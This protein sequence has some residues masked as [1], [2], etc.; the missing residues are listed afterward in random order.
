MI[1]RITGRLHRALVLVMVLS[2]VLPYVAFADT[3]E[4]DAISNSNANNEQL[5]YTAGSS[6]AFQSK[7][8]VAKTGNECDPATGSALSFKLMATQQ[9]D[10]NGDAVNVD[11]SGAI[12][13]KLN[14]TTNAAQSLN[15]FTLTFSACGDAN[16]KT[17]DFTT[18]ST[19]AAGKYKI[20]V[21]SSTISDPG[22][23]DSYQVNNA[24]FFVQVSASTNQAPVANNQSVTTS[25]DTAKPITLTGSDTNTGDTL[26]YTVVTQPTKGQLT[27]TAPNLTYTPNANYNGSDSFTFKI[28]DGTVD[29]NT[30]TVS[31]TV[32]AVNDAPVAAND[33]ARTDEDRAVAIDVLAN[34]TDVENNSLSVGAGSITAPANGTATLITSDENAGKILYT[35]NGNFNG[36]DS[37]TYKVCD[38]GTSGGS[39][40]PKCST[41]SATVS[42]RVLAQNDA[43][44]AQNDAASTGEDTARVIDVLANDN[45]GAANESGQTLS[46]KADSITA[47]AYGTA[48]LITSGD[49]AGKIRYTPSND[50]NGS[51][52]FRYEVCDNG[53]SESVVNGEITSSADA[54]CS[55]S[56]ATVSLTVSAVND[57]PVPAGDTASTPEDT[58]LYIAPST[59][60]ENDSKGAAN[61]GTQTLTI[62]AVSNAVKGAV[63][64]VQADDQDAEGNVGK[65]RFVP[66]ANYNGTGASFDYKVCD[67]GSPQLCSE[68]TA[69]VTVT[70][71]P[72]ND[73]P[74]AGDDSFSTNEDTR[75]DLTQAQLK[76]NDTDVDNSELSVTA[77][78]NDTNGTAVKNT[79]G[80]VTFTP[81]RDFNGTAGFDYT[82]S[83][84]E[85]TDTGHVTVMVNAVNDK[86]TISSIADQETDEDVAKGPLNFTIGDVDNNLSVLTVSASS[87]NT[88]LVPDNKISLSGTGAEWT[89]TV[90]PAA[91]KHGEAT[92]TLTVCDGTSSCTEEVFKLTVNSVN[93]APDAVN[94]NAEGTED[95]TSYIN[96]LSNDTDVDNDALS[97]SSVSIDATN[98]AKATVSV[99][100]DGEHKGKISFV[101]ARD[102]NGP[103]TFSYTA[104]DGKGGTDTASVTVSVAAVNDAPVATD[105]RG[106]STDEDN[107][108]YIDPADLLVNDSDVDNTLAQLSL[109][110]IS[111]ASNGRVSIVP[112][113]EANAG[114]IKFQPNANY[115]GPASFKYTIT[116]GKLDSDKATVSI[117]VNAVNDAPSFTKGAN[118]TV[119]EDAG[120][121]SVA[122][123]ATNI[124]K[125]AANEGSQELTFN[126]GNDNRA[127]FSAQPAISAD[128][129]LTYTPAANANGSATVT[130]SLSDDG[131]TDNGGK[132]TSGTQ[133]FTIAI[134]AVNDAPSFTKGANQ[135]VPE[136]A[137]AQNVSGWATAI[138]A[139]PANEAGQALDFIVTN[140]NNGL[141]SAQPA[142][143]T[144]GTLSFTPAANK[145]GSTTVTVQLHDDGGTANGGAD[146]SAEQTFTITVTEV[147]DAPTAADDAK[148]GTEDT[149]LR[150]AVSDLLANDSAGPNEA[151]QTLSVRVEATANTHGTVS[152]DTST[153]QVVYT[154]AANY[155]G[156][157]SFSYTITDNG[158][159]NGTAD[160]RSASATVRLT[161]A[162]VN[163]APTADAQS[164]ST[165]EDTAKT[166]NLLG[167]DVEDDALTYIVVSQP[168]N[169]ALTG[170]APNL[171]YTPNSNY[172]GTDSFTFKVNDGSVDSSTAT[173][174]ITVNAV[175]DAPGVTI[176]S[177]AVDQVTG[178]ASTGISWSDVDASDRETISFTYTAGGKTVATSSYSDRAASGSLTD[179]A[180]IPAGCY[181]D[182]KV[183]VTITDN[184]TPSLSG[185]DTRSSSTQ[186]LDVYK[187]S[188]KAPIMDNERNLAKAGS[189]VPVKVALSSMCNP[190]ATVTNRNLYVQ[191]ITGTDNETLVGDEVVTSSVSAADSG[192]QMRVV[193]GMYIYNLSTK[194]LTTGQDYTIRIWVDG[195]DTT[196]MSKRILR[197]VLRT[198]K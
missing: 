77:V 187:A 26:T 153:N 122:S 158:T 188:F 146:T 133:T 98:A 8:W 121:Q 67:N 172:N 99:V 31:I 43:P 7:Y 72:V 110:D 64:I 69:K 170:T 21:K 95:T 180:A 131:G 104:S 65:V 184:G 25:E 145:Y 189:V 39:S 106:F 159:T 116:D 103:V 147:N 59:L 193:D 90:T 51:D 75:L 132:D 115:N 37:F 84:G 30:A 151:D 94:D 16:S 44:V 135:T 62:S 166:I 109:K 87:S 57:A 143:A 88:T 169:G 171:T 3:I 18:G 2:L 38:N 22:S 33:S 50:F 19:L 130:V 40:D 92:I 100:A 14:G 71:D 1:R 154:P 24:H 186:Q 162:A 163:D 190:G 178:R 124:S 105:D 134:N 6:T 45:K 41:A 28:N 96:V 82:V 63:S 56:A 160:H 81:A 148:N 76:G 119:L 117:T 123:W 164:V 12:N 128:G 165:N 173:V 107:A 176:T 60:T 157:A 101:P 137:G 42:A 168:S 182:L 83:D 195:V 70:V 61:E 177:F 141:F 73:A 150:F 55:A 89:V 140:T 108:L 78:S 66:E 192:T 198:T 126:V 194:G 91:N 191:V 49:D 36:S 175:N 113:D 54:R 196:N 52:S 35:P 174:S 156:A 149:E 5:S 80:T 179:T 13:A 48:E 167:R 47:P 139:G 114:K 197:A 97:V 74:V 129:T 68:G 102:F 111:D 17:V 23:T 32:S 58:T 161:I 152:I 27:G 185:T 53:T 15:D 79:D 120:A 127:L 118:Q 29:S 85:K 34:D 93:D 86:P 138:S 144:N 142:V 136:D 10:A 155:N 125:G 9:T 181:T 20:E 112:A 11:A 183:I 4:G 46:V